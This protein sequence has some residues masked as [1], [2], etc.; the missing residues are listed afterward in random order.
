MRSFILYDNVIKSNTKKEVTQMVPHHQYQ[1]NKNSP[2]Y[3]Q[4]KMQYVHAL[5]TQLLLIETFPF[6]IFNDGS[7]TLN[8]SCC[9]TLRWFSFH[10]INIQDIDYTKKRDSFL[11]MM[12]KNIVFRWNE[13]IDAVINDSLELVY[14]IIQNFFFVLLPA[15]PKL[16]SFTLNTIYRGVYIQIDISSDNNR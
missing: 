10:R 7:I 2:R 15:K 3:T 12:D 6:F 9:L 13:S 16:P 14:F 5:G 1:F 8:N 4:R 11:I